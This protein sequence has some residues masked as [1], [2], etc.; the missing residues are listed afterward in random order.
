MTA[1]AIIG[2]GTIIYFIFKQIVKPQIVH[3]SIDNQKLINKLYVLCN[4]HPKVM[5]KY[6]ELELHYDEPCNFVPHEL[7][8]KDEL[9]YKSGLAKSL[10]TYISALE[11]NPIEKKNIDNILKEQKE[12]T[13]RCKKVNEI[14]YYGLN[15]NIAEF[16]EIIKSIFSDSDRKQ[17]GIEEDIFINELISK[18]NI[19]AGVIAYAITINSH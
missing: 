15:K 19:V 5:K 2:I 1:L 14:R 6:L 18:Y 7:Y 4:N 16:G 13:I 12:S 9:Y 3:K 10:C 11:N 8:F 17:N